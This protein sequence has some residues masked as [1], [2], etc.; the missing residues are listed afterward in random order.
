MAGTASHGSGRFPRLQLEPPFPWS[1]MR[2]SERV[3]ALPRKVSPA[4]QCAVYRIDRP[5]YLMEPSSRTP[6]GEPNRCPVCGKDL[7]IEPSRPPGNAPCPHCGSLLWFG[8]PKVGRTGSMPLTAFGINSACLSNAEITDARLSELSMVPKLYYLNLGHTQ[9]TDARI[10]LL[11]GL[12][13]LRDLQLCGCPIGD[14]A[15]LY[16]KENKE[17]TH[18]NLSDTRITDAGLANLTPFSRLRSLVLS[19]T[20]ITGVGMTHL[21]GLPQPSLSS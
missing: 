12:S 11:A 16:L 3:L 15:L 2:L 18:L 17:L 8:P 19:G 21:I 6:E 20:K 14:G 9:I 13:E 4:G 5:K 7:C 1:T 10:A